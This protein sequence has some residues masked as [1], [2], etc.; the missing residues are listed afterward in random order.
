MYASGRLAPVQFHAQPPRDHDVHAQI[1]LTLLEQALARSELQQPDAGHERVE[2]LVA[3]ALQRLDLA[4]QGDA[5]ARRGADSPR[6]RPRGSRR[7]AR[8]A[9]GPVG[10]TSKLE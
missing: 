10:F 2:D 6:D 3:R 4:Q 8:E 1:R 7:F 5:Y 9:H